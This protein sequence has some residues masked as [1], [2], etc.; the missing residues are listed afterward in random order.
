M[1]MQAECAPG[2]SLNEAEGEASRAINFS[3]F[4]MVAIVSSAL[5]AGVT[6]LHLTQP[7]DGSRELAGFIGGLPFC[8]RALVPSN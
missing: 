4:M 8:A 5:S 7:S 1:L 3:Q 2:R 6:Y